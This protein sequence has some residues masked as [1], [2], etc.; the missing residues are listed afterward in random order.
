MKRALRLATAGARRLGRRAAAGCPA[1]RTGSPRAGRGRGRIELR[2]GG[3]AQVRARTW[4]EARARRIRR[5]AGLG[6]ARSP[7]VTGASGEGPAAR[8]RGQS[9]ARS[10]GHR[11]GA[12]AAAEAC[13]PSVP[14]RACGPSPDLVLRSCATPDLLRATSKARPELVEGNVPVLAPFA[15]VGASP[16]QARAGSSRRVAQG[17]AAQDAV[18]Q[19]CSPSKSADASPAL[20]RSVAEHVIVGDFDVLHLAIERRAADAE[21]ARHLRHWPR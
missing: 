4:R 17:S 14:E 21:L 13:A 12:Q 16:R 15:F 8:R 7:N 18:E 5:S 10:A 9:E 6:S 19:K 1:R 2:L 3:Q 11:D 20:C